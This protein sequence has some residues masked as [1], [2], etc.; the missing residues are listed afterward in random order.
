MKEGDDFETELLSHDRSGSPPR[1]RADRNAARTLLPRF[2]GRISTRIRR[3][4]NFPCH[5]GRNRNH[6]SLGA[7]SMREGHQMRSVTLCL[8]AML[9]LPGS[10]DALRIGPIV[11]SLGVYP[12][13]TWAP[14]WR[15]FVAEE[16]M[17]LMRP[18]F[19]S[20][21]PGEWFAT[22]DVTSPLDEILIRTTGRAAPARWG[23]ARATVTGLR[24]MRCDTHSCET[25]ENF[26]LGTDDPF[27]SSI[28]GIELQIFEWGLQVVDV[29]A[30]NYVLATSLTGNAIR[31][32]PDQSE[33]DLFDYTV[34]LIAIWTIPEPSTAVTLGLGLCLLAR[35]RRR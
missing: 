35:R 29:P 22:L 3:I 1:A 11:G 14:P 2:R 19:P 21:D 18:D 23:G 6:S 15:P 26:A 16:T 30:G 10:A 17:G 31:V 13:D 34:D 12:D 9:L 28:F 7:R 25:G 24:L 33:L 27:L 32:L 8:A 20:Q 5:A 4:Q